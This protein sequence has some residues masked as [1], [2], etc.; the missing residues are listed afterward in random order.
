MNPIEKLRALYNKRETAEEIYAL[1]LRIRGM[2][3]AD[4]VI[5]ATE[6]LTNAMIDLAPELIALWEAA[7]RHPGYSGRV[8]ID[9]ALAALNAKAAEVFK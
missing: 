9:E 5:A 8:S 7:S 1:E 6:D 4:S 2:S 3:C